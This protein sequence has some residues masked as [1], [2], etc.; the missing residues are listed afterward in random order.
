MHEKQHEI[1][2]R[3]VR[4]L[5][6]GPFSIRTRVDDSLLKELDERATQNS[7][8]YRKSLAGR[9]NHEV[10]YSDENIK[11]FE[12]Q[13][14]P[15]F[16]LYIHK[17]QQIHLDPN[18]K[19][20]SPR[21][22]LMSLWMNYMRAGEYNPIHNHAGSLSFVIYVDVPKEIYQEENPAN[23][24]APGTITFMNEIAFFDRLPFTSDKKEEEKKNTSINH[25]LMPTTSYNLMPKTGEMIIFPS[26]LMHSVE[27]FQS[28]VIRK[29]VSGNIKFD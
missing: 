3:D 10:R 21:G 14:A 18:M 20:N 2:N 16:N 4:T 24:H 27:A 6:F 29:T 9:L 1:M 17:L 8:D 5:P 15:Y 25:Y 7:S 23:G 11:Y 26:Y 22:Q 19:F 12:K 13:L 28:N